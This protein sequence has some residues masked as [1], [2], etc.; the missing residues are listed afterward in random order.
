MVLIIDAGPVI[1]VGALKVSGQLRIV[2][3]EGAE[4]V[5]EVVAGRLGLRRNGREEGAVD[6]L[7]AV[8]LRRAGAGERHADVADDDRGGL[9]GHDLPAVDAAGTAELACPERRRLD[10]NHP[11]R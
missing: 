8:A 3:P 4:E 9:K 7:R 10:V 11:A 5:P 6:A 2:F 1:D